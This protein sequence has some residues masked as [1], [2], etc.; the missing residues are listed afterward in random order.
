MY[1]AYCSYFDKKDTIAKKFLTILTKEEFEG[2]YDKWTW[3]EG[4][5]FYKFI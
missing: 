1:A 2:D 3:I 4:G 5:F